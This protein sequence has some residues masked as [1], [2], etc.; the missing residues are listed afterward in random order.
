MQ[1]R[2]RKPEELGRAR[3]PEVNVAVTFLDD[4]QDNSNARV[5]AGFSVGLLDALRLTVVVIS[6]V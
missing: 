1:V 5:H 2:A 4:C 3:Q 6:L